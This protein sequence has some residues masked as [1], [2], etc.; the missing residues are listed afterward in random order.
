MNITGNAEIE[1]LKSPSSLF[2]PFDE[3]SPYN[4]FRPWSSIFVPNT[5]DGTVDESSYYSFL[6]FL[7]HTRPRYEMNVPAVA[8]GIR[9]AIRKRTKKKKK[10]DLHL[11]AEQEVRRVRYGQLAVTAP[12]RTLSSLSRC[13]HARARGLPLS[14]RIASLFL[15]LSSF[16]THG[17]SAYDYF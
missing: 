15:P 8:S 1:I 13:K 17:Y 6:E 4:N 2:R 16:C 12:S 11:F 10:E 9:D 5:T 14:R 3:T 7:R